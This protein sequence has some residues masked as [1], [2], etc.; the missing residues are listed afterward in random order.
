MGAADADAARAALGEVLADLRGR[1]ASQSPCR[2][3]TGARRV[4]ILT[5]A[6]YAGIGLAAGA[7]GGVIAYES[8]QP[9]AVARR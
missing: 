5:A 7:L 8:G 6:R 2:G 9:V 1:G 3:L 4:R